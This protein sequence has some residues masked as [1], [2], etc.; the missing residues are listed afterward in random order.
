MR[1]CRRSPLRYDEVLCRGLQGAMRLL[2]DQLSSNCQRGLSLL[3]ARI[4]SQP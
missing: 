4:D 1:A 2:S 3:G